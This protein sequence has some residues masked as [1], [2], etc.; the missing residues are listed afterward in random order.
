MSWT[1]LTAALAWRA[2]RSPSL[3]LALLRVMWNFRARGWWR[4]PPFLPI[5]PRAYIEW[6]MYT[7]Y[8]DARALPS[9]EEVERYARWTAKQ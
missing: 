8:G 5:P 7:A 4:K 6:R 1:R 3:G 9:A 2:I